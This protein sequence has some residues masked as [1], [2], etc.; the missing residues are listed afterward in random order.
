MPGPFVP[1]LL[2]AHILIAASSG[3]PTIDVAT[4]CRTSE[5]EIVK[6]FGDT[7]AATFEGCMR[8]ENE[9]LERIQKDWAAYSASAKAHCVQA[10]SYMPS[11]VEWLTCLEMEQHLKELRAKEAEVTPP[12]PV[13][14]KR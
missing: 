9:A 12:A 6:I 10:K 2:G 8:Q 14:R 13:P 5:K 7:T 4:T 3:P 1:L 11:Y